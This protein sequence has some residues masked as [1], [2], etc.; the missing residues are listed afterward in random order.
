MKRK[1][2]EFIPFW[3]RI[4]HPE[5][6]RNPEFYALKTKD[7][8]Q[9]EK[10][11]SEGPW[12]IFYS[13]LDKVEDYLKFKIR[14]HISKRINNYSEEKPFKVFDLGCGAGVALNELKKKF[15][16]KIRTVGLVLKLPDS[17]LNK[18]QGLEKLDRLIEGRLAE[19]NP[20][21]SFDLIYSH[22]GATVY[23]SKRLES[24]QKIIGWLRPGGVAILEISKIN[25]ELKTLLMQNGIK[26][27]SFRKRIGFRNPVL[28]FKKPKRILP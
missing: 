4:F 26:K 19:I 23:E 14:T 9:V 5:H 27:Y 20:R 13:D 8:A 18:S 10:C 1:I 6:K 3:K 7:L 17:F 25:N 2:S 12:G 28:E 16:A 22:S 21:E 15:G 11:D 24:V